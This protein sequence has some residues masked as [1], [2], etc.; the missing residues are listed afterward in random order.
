MMVPKKSLILAGAALALF[1]ASASAQSQSGKVFQRNNKPLKSASIDL[2]TGTITR[3]PVVSNRAGTTV[4]DFFNNDLSNWAG[5]D[6]GN[7]FC[8]W[9]D[10][11]TKG[12]GFAQPGNNFNFMN[13]FRFVYCSAEK[14]ISLGGPGGTIKMG[15]YEGWTSGGGA[16]TTAVAV[17]T[18][19]GLPAH[20]ISGDITTG[21]FSCYII[22]LTFG[23]PVAFADGSIGY[24]WKFMDVGTVGL[25]GAT[26]PVMSC[27]TSCTGVG[28]VADGQGM[29]DFIDQ[30]CP[31]GTLRSHFSFKTLFGAPVIFTTVSMEIDEPADFAATIA[32]YN[33][34]IAPLNAFPLT[35]SKVILNTTWTLTVGVGPAAAGKPAT[36][37]IFSTRAA[38]NGFPAT[39]AGL[40]ATAGRIM[41]SGSNLLG[42]GGLTVTGGTGGV[43]IAAPIPPLIAL[44]AVHWASQAVVVAGGAL[45]IKLSSAAEGTDGTF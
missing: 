12:T 44:I 43:G 26:F 29:I 27:I 28:V 9:F 36:A 35:A 8:E 39:A 32:L 6:T 37:F 42:G 33:N 3:G 18:L 17:F 23:T 11:A 4:A 14:D 40:P 31:P 16:A 7:G 1:G 15:F 25:L 20:T 38:G 13:D 41:I 30:Y 2:A 5:V 21:T 19:S 24:S 45:G 10:A 22:T 34:T